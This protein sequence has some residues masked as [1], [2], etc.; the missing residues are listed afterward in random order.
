MFFRFLFLLLF[1]QF[2]FLL[3]LFQ[4]PAHL[5]LQHPRPLFLTHQSWALTFSSPCR[6]LPVRP[7]CQEY[8]FYSSRVSLLF[9]YS[10]RVSLLFIKS[11]LFYSSRV[12][13]FIHQEWSLL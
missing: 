11:G 13:S 5:P 4:F 9:F 3:P 12:V 8:L 2:A 7:T 6:E 1:L 10:S